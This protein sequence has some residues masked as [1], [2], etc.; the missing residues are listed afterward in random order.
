MSKTRNAAKSSETAMKAY[1][2]YELTLTPVEVS[3]E[4]E[5]EWREDSECWQLKWADWVGEGRQVRLRGQQ[6]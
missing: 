5:E 2:T 3:D 1:V 4:E 6:R